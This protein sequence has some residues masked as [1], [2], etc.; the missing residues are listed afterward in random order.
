MVTRKIRRLA[1]AGAML[2]APL[3]LLYASPAGADIY[4]PRLSTGGCITGIADMQDGRP[5]CRIIS[6]DTTFHNE[7]DGGV[8]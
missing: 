5:V 7:S 3:G 6:N 8:W 1:L 2:L 4:N